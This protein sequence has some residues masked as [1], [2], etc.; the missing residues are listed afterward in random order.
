MWIVVLMPTRLML[1]AHCTRLCYIKSTL[2]VLDYN[3]CTFYCR[4]NIWYQLINFNFI[5][6]TL[7]VGVG[8][9]YYAHLLSIT[10]RV[11][12]IS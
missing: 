1:F 3:V 12:Y 7:H 5:Y 10:L 9:I 4:L 6:G 11:W 8:G 2:F